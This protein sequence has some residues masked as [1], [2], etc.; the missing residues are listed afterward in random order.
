ML[1]KY[2][3]PPK[4]W[5]STWPHVLYKC[6]QTTITAF[7]RRNIPWNTLII[8]DC[9]SQLHTLHFT[10]FLTP[11]KPLFPTTRHILSPAIYCHQR[12]KGL[13]FVDWSGSR[14]YWL[15]DLTCYFHF[16]IKLILKRGYRSRLRLQQP[17]GCCTLVS[18]H[19]TIQPGSA[20]LIYM[21][22]YKTITSEF[23]ALSKEILNPK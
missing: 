23:L 11:A 7:P 13:L 22:F 1:Y 21:S 4:L 19:F 12:E 10:R 9:C 18:T 6:S 14:S 5:K 20:P 15:D 2:T 16:R 17:Q 3:M 8:K